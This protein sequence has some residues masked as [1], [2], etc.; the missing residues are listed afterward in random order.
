MNEENVVAVVP[1]EEN[2]LE[3]GDSSM[4]LDLFAE[5]SE[6]ETVEIEHPF[7]TTS[8][9]DYTVSEGLLLTIVLILVVKFCID[10]LR[11]GFYWL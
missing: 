11:R 6:V 7:L 1:D 3:T 9:E 8:F 5:T 10:S 2:V 4:A